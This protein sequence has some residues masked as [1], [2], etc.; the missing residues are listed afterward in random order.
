MNYSELSLLVVDHASN[1]RSSLCYQLEISGFKSILQAKGIKDALYII[2]KKKIQ[3]IISE[4][5]KPSDGLGILEAIR[6]EEKFANLPVI[7][8]TDTP[9][10]D[11]AIQAI[12]LSVND[13]V[14]KP[15]TTKTLINRIENIFKSK[16]D[17]KPENEVNE[18]SE[19]KEINQ[20]S[21]SNTILI[22]DDTPDNLEFVSDIFK[23]FYKIKIATGGEKALSICASDGTPD[24]ILLDV[25]M[26]NMDGF[27]V[28]KKLRENYLTS[29][30]PIIFISSLAEDEAKMKAFTLGAID[31]VSKPINPNI[32]KLRV[33]NLMNLVEKRKQIQ[34][35][36]D[37][38]IE[39]DNLKKEIKKL[40][41]LN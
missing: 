7:L 6:K 12:S 21:E 36:M 41:N 14:V 38:L 28:A 20:S 34:S 31:F 32:L 11:L 26:P 2:N 29:H 30:I 13:F 9:N 24:L 35:N 4:L 17:N 16:N 5:S 25:M 27:E 8:Y 19:E 40:K 37:N 39:I 15:F 18:V 22:V 3:L 1:L 10:K 23:D 33:D